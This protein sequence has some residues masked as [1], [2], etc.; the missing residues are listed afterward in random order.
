MDKEALAVVVI[1]VG[2]I[3]VNG[4][5]REGEIFC[6]SS[7]FNNVDLPTFGRPTMAINPQ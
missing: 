3:A 5:K 7:L 2:V 6:P 1:I 4:Q